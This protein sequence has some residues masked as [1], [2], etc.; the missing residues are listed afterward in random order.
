MWYPNKHTNIVN[1]HD[2]N[3]VTSA[4]GVAEPIHSIFNEGTLLGETLYVKAIGCHIGN[5]RGNFL[6]MQYILTH[7][8]YENIYSTR[9][10]EGNNNLYDL[11]EDSR[12]LVRRMRIMHQ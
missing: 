8:L 12:L 6:T 5:N 10:H 1:D 3:N 2:I 4:K 9:I 11:C 7:E